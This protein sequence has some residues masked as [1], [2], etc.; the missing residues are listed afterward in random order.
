MHER[1]PRLSMILSSLQIILIILRSFCIVINVHICDSINV[2]IF[3]F[4][5]KMNIKLYITRTFTTYLKLTKEMI[6]IK[7]KEMYEKHNTM[8]SFLFVWVNVREKQKVS[9]YHWAKADV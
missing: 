8:E 6:V 2:F 1:K 3:E 4:F 9:W 5:L 7:S